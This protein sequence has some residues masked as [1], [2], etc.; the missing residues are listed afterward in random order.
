MRLYHFATIKIPQ[1]Y[2]E[3]W[4]L[5]VLESIH[6]E[7]Q[8]HKPN[9]KKVIK[10]TGTTSD[11]IA[12]IQKYQLQDTYLCNRSNKTFFDTD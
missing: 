10:D 4:K 2:F 11:V 5:H 8:S 7:F 12:Y 3:I 6:C 1:K 9:V